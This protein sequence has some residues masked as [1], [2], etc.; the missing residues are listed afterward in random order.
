MVELRNVL[1][2]LKNGGPIFADII[3][4]VESTSKS[5]KEIEFVNKVPHNNLPA[6]YIQAV[7]NS[8]NEYIS[9]RNLF[10]IKVT[11]IDGSFH[12]INSS[13]MAFTLVAEN[14]IKK[15][16]EQVGLTTL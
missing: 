10:G 3:I 12:P 4:R 2:T 5:N 8:V 14:A 6:V 13:E 9:C 16:I 11:L 1:N 7:K 15:A